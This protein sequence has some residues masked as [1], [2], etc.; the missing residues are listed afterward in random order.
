MQMPRLLHKN[1]D[2]SAQINF[3]ERTALLSFMMSNKGAAPT[4][5]GEN[6]HWIR[7]RAKAPRWAIRVCL[8]KC[9]LRNGPFR[10]VQEILLKRISWRD[11]SKNFRLVRCRLESTLD[12]RTIGIN[13]H[14]NEAILLRG[15]MI[16]TRLCNPP[17]LLSSFTKASS[18]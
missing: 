6:S 16:G 8:G 10:K 14:K 4:C 11:R 12:R 17:I 1:A 9:A 18:S 3:A 7:G 5:S 2:F 13:A 15:E